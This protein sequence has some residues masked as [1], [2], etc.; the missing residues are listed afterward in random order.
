MPPFIL[1]ASISM[2]WCFADERTPYSRD[3]L[4]QLDYTY[5]EVP[6][7]WPLE[8]ANV[9]AV[10][11]RKG[12]LQISESTE[13]LK[14]LSRLDIRIEQRPAYPG[15]LLPLIRRHKLTAYD[16]AYLDLAKRTGF[17]LASF[18]TDLI[19]AAKSEGIALFS[20]R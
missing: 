19:D 18:D 11:E 9:L 17:A 20:H 13:F 10:N 3:V 15:D 2:S 14:T 7:I 5:A 4:K 12:R 6:T 1:D 16:A 8:I